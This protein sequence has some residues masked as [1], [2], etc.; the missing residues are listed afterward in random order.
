MLT[1]TTVR[2]TYQGDGNTTT[3]AIPFSFIRDDSLET[4]VY[5]RDESVDPATESLQTEGAQQ[6]YVLTGAQTQDDFN[7]DVE[8]NSAPA[9]TSKVIII[10]KRPL[11]Q[12]LDL[13]TSGAYNPESQ[14]LNYDDIVAMVQELDERVSRT[15]VQRITSQDGSL[16]FPEKEKGKFLRVDKNTGELIW[17]DIPELSG[18]AGDL[19]SPSDG[20]Y[21]SGVNRANVADGDD[22]E[23]AFD[24]VV[25]LQDKGSY[26]RKF[27]VSHTDLQAAST[28]NTISL[29]TASNY[30]VIEYAII[31][32][33][34]SFKGGSISSYEVEVGP[35]S[36]SD[37]YMFAFDVFQSPGDDV[38]KIQRNTDVE[39][40][41]SSTTIEMTANSQGDNL[42]QST[43]G[44]LNIWVKTAYLPS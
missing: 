16:E 26:F 28:S 36:D 34:T 10:R 37:K 23:D 14:E 33:S 11:T 44:E 9:S 24:K 30:E 6:D 31:K 38:K 42:D 41:S 15:A 39:S 12:S 17:F 35:S 40:F 5:I 19:E 18:G 25:S 1:N 20:T 27:T 4:Q 32:H 7:T 13:T 2:A 21:G 43:Q 29:F 22:V 8:F 3:F